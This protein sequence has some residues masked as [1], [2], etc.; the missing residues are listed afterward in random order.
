MTLSRAVIAK[1]EGD[2]KAKNDSFN[3]SN[4]R[5]TPQKNYMKAR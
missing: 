4:L 5:F 2:R 1:H 3:W